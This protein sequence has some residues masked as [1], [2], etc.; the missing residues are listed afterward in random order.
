MHPATATPLRKATASRCIA[1]VTLAAIAAVAAPAA[2]QTKEWDQPTVTALAQ[3]LADAAKQTNQS[4]RRQITRA[5]VE[6]DPKGQRYLDTLRSLERSTAKLARQLGEGKG[7]EET[8]NTARR[9]RTQVRD[10][11]TLAPGF[12]T[13]QQ[14]AERA[15][16]AVE[17]LDALAPFYFDDAETGGTPGR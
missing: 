4:V 15:A 17:A 9:I 5:D 7:R 10:L 14:T 12:F 8:L 3:Q 6:G 13:T 16:P 2:A 1:L 11:R